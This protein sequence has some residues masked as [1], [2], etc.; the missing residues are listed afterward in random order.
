MSFLNK[1]VLAAAVV[2]SLFAGSAFAA[3]LDVTR[4]YYAEEIVIPS[5][6][7]VPA[8]APSLSWASGYNYSN[9]E[10]KYVR[11]E[12][13]GA[14]FQTGLVA[15]AVSG[16]SVGAINGLGTNVI[17]FSVTSTGPTGAPAVGGINAASVF[18]LPLA[19]QINIPA[20]A[21]VSVKV[22]LY[23]QASQA[24]AGGTNGLL[25]IGSYDNTVFLSFARSYEFANT[26]N[27]LTANVSSATR[28]GNFSP[29]GSTAPPTT[30]VA[31]TLNNNLSI[32]LRDPDGSAG[33]WV[34]A[35]LRA[36]G[37][38]ITLANLFGAGSSIAVEGN[39][40]AASS[41]TL[42]GAVSTPAPAS[43][44]PFY[45]TNTL[46][47]S[48]VPTGSG[49]LV[50]NVPGTVAIPA[51]DF[52]ATFTP[53][54]ASAAYNVTPLTANV[55]GSIRRNG[56]EL[57]APLAQIPAGWISRLVLTNTGTATPAYSISVLGETGNTI[58]TANTTGTVARGANVI[59]LNTVMTGFTA[60]QA[61][62][63]TIV[64]NV[65]STDAPGTGTIQG[66]Y[67]IVNP[68]SGSISNHVLVRPGT[69]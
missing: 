38:P 4:Q 33:P 46:T 27:T 21:D 50:Y 7:L 56:L 15:P 30:A 49:A 66:L 6:G 35:P 67:Q 20:A 36:D 37:T 25:A 34:G 42:G 22:S 40:A 10:V 53:V 43:A 60:G 47:W 62:R 24:Q 32:R 48:G 23:D 41:V 26:A 69:N 57:Q 12:L 18:S 64:V 55:V 65:E 9:N 5:T 54:A 3:P 2:G 1:K 31:G 63:G 51:G 59:D 11:V 61:P 58:S 14:T 17:T 45:S 8:L 39:F 19:G 44:A 16:G 29:D 52:R 68:T 28:Y 13:T